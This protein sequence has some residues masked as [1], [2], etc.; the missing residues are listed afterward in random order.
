MNIIDIICGMFLPASVFVCGIY[1]TARIGRFTLSPKRILSGLSTKNTPKSEKN[2][3]QRSPFTALCMA[4]AGTLGVG[5]ITGVASAIAMGGAG[6]VFWMW[7]CGLAS[8][9]LKFSET[10]LA[11]K[12][13]VTDKNGASHG[14][15]FYYIKNGLKMPKLAAAFSVLCVIASFFT[16]NM[17]QIRSASD[18]IVLCTDIPISLMAFISAA[19]ILIIILSG[20]KFIERF[21]VLTIPAL[22]VTYIIMSGAVI[23]IRREAIGAVTEMIFREAFSVRAGAGGILGFL[24]SGAMRYGVCRGIMSSEAGCG[25]API[26]HAGAKNTGISQGYLGILEVFCDTVL[27]CSLTAYVVLL[28]GVVRTGSASEIA[29]CAFETV[30]GSGAKI[31]LGASMFMFAIASVAGWSHY[32][33]ESLISIGGTKAD[34]RIFYALFVL[35]AAFSCYLP[36][37]FIWDMS[38][39][40][41]SALAVINLTAMIGLRHDLRE[42]CNSCTKI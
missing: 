21:T 18:G 34:F 31:I 26:A 19:A 27:L 28:S 35:S 3:K 7:V 10:V 5:N 12:Y 1:F 37:R 24:A 22:C 42:I 8:S 16:G 41:I 38:D 23:F 32:A 25:T 9:V 11:M 30:L 17:A 36:E 4:L 20:E 39:I 14:G 40:T 29:L 6:A 33:R 13:R 2:G 15:P